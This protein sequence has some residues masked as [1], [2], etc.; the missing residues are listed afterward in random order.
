M[1]VAVSESPEDQ[2]AYHQFCEQFGV[3]FADLQATPES[4]ACAAYGRYILDIGAQGESIYCSECESAESRQETSSTC[5]W[6]SH[7][8]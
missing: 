3:S 1:H 7:L 6:A 2:T 8:V 5:T 4:A